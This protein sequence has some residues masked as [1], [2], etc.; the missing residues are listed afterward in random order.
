MSYYPS[1]TLWIQLTHENDSHERAEVE[2]RADVMW[3]SKGKSIWSAGFRMLRRP[4]LTCAMANLLHAEK[5]V[6]KRPRAQAGSDD[7]R[8]TL[9]RRVVHEVKLKSC[10]LCFAFLAQWRILV[11][12]THA[13]N[14][15]P[16]AEPSL[17]HRKVNEMHSVGRRKVKCSATRNMK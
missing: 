9:E 7:G 10:L 1:V 14:L 6:A 15:H 8:E 17:W 13:T 4:H 3:C 12:A 2:R 11:V 16:S 5:G